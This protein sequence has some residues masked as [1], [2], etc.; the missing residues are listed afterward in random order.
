MKVH[1][2]QVVAGCMI[3]QDVMGKTN[4]PIIPK[5]TVVHPIH[6]RV[7]NQFK[8]GVVEVANRLSDG[9]PFIPEESIEYNEVEEH[10]KQESQESLSTLS[11]QEQY[12]EAV[13]A[14]K[15]WFED[16]RG[17][18]PV[19]ISAVRKVMVPLLERAAQSN[20]DV[21]LLHHFSSKDDY[22]Y[23]HSVAVGLLSGYIAS[24]MN[25]SYGDWIQIGLAGV[26]SD[27]GMAKVEA[28][29]INKTGALREEEFNQIRKHPTYSYRYVEKT[30]LLTQNAKLAI[31][32][33][34]ERLDGSG[35]PLGLQQ[36]KIHSYSQIIAVSDMYHAMTSERAYRKKHSPFRVLEEI[37]KEQ[38]GR[39]DHT[40][41]QAFIK[42][43]TNYSQ[44]TKV[45][46]SNNQKAAIVFVESS[47][48]TRPMVQ[49]E[50]QS[51]YALRDHHDLYIEEVLD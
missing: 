45:K 51:I 9:S 20:R 13:Q 36:G 2:S 8:V 6:M 4:R 30:P 28:R 31:L 33:H 15:K 34:H 27:S 38:F 39:F 37:Q 32:Q 3:I 29:I 12:L 41:V 22:Y 11:F 44:G 42:E 23:H 24:K 40:V 18:T 10:K 5:N 26:L 1:P 25:Y 49:L 35:Y 47:H 16:W 48:P 50:D 19:D 7:L 43:M 21:F 46:L 17:G 14:Y